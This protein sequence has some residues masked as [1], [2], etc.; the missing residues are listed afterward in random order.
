M[1]K[2]IMAEDDPFLS[3]MYERS[4][5]DT[6]YELEIATDGEDAISKLNSMTILPSVIML[7][8]IMPKKN[9]L[10]VLKEIKQNEKLKNIPVIMLTNQ[11][12]DNDQKIAMSLGAVLYLVKSQY[13]P[14]QIVDMVKDVTGGQIKS[15]YVPN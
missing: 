11:S 10:T 4:F 12:D 1:V 9:G 15:S 8:I 5:R 7:D 2:I 14:K 3:R 6:G 13:G